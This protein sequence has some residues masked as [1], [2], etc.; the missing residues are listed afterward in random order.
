LA[1]FSFILRT[2]YRQCVRQ[3]GLSKQLCFILFSFE[4]FSKQKILQLTQLSKIFYFQSGLQNCRRSEFGNKTKKVKLEP[5]GQQ[6]VYIEFG[7]KKEK[8]P[9]IIMAAFVFF[10]VMRR[11]ARG[12][13]QHGGLLGWLEE[14]DPSDVILYM[15]DWPY[16]RLSFPYRTGCP[17]RSCP[18]PS[19]E[20]M[21]FPA[22]VL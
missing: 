22:A 9:K 2:K 4:T 5:G 6:K 3:P 13:A 7:T 21:E 20:L 16:H 17:D 12:L 11:K 8:E 1:N 18:L 15:M 10:I 19:C 14:S